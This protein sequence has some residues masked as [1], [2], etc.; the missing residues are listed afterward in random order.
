VKYALEKL[1]AR[2]VGAVVAHLTGGHVIYSAAALTRAI[3][4][5]GNVPVGIIR[6]IETVAVP[7]NAPSALSNCDF[8]AIMHRTSW[9]T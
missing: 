5:R 3:R 9:F 2:S 1:R 6:G 7:E 8:R 4:S